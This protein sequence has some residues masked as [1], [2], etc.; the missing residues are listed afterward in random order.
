M[1]LGRSPKQNTSL[2]PLKQQKFNKT[3]PFPEKIRVEN[4]VKTRKTNRANLKNPH[5][6]ARNGF[7][8]KLLHIENVLND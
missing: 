6:G 5:F 1:S 2:I 7:Q 4:F 8:K 3:M